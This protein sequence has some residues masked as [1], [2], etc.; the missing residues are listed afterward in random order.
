[1]EPKEMEEAG[2]AGEWR[3]PTP[4]PVEDAEQYGSAAWQAR[5][6]SWSGDAREAMAL[7]MGEAWVRRME[8]RAEVERRERVEAWLAWA[9]EQA[10]GKAETGEQRVEQSREQGVG[11][12]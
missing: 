5:V 12:R 8:E 1:M 2:E 3:H 11:S 9:G 10:A 4:T 6:R 7:M